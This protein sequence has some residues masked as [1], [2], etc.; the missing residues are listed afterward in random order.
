MKPVII[1]SDQADNLTHRFLL[2]LHESFSGLNIARLNYENWSS[3]QSGG[4]VIARAV[5]TS[6]DSYI[7]AMRLN[8][9][10]KVTGTSI[11]ELSDYRTRTRSEASLPGLDSGLV[12]NIFP[13]VPR[14][15][16]E[17]FTR[18]TETLGLKELLT[19]YINS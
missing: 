2:G 13:D 7:Y 4:V 8:R 1:W 10:A 17:G 3:I 6:P 12:G 16:F 9:I 11:F 5:V 19:P 15:I 14:G 18:R